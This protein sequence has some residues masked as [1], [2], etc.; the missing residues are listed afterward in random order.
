MKKPVLP[1][2]AG[3]LVLYLAVFVILVTIQSVRQQ[4]FTHRLGGMTISGHYGEADALAGGAPSAPKGAKGFTLTG[5]VSVFFG[6]MEFRMDGKDGEFG[7]LRRGGGK[8]RLLPKYLEISDGTSV[9]GT[10]V[11]ESAAVYFTNAEVP[12]SGSASNG[13]VLPGIK[14]IFTSFSTPGGPELRITG[15][16]GGEFMGAELPYQ[17]MRSARIQES[18]GNQFIILAEGV[19]YSFDRSRT[20]PMRKVLVLEDQGSAISYRA[21]SNNK[22]SFPADFV[23]S[24]AWD[25]GQYEEAIAYWRDQLFSIWART[26]PA[27]IDTEDLVAAYASEA[28]HRGNYKDVVA[29]IPRSFQDS[30]RRTYISSVFFGRLDISLR[31]L[32][33]A[34]RDHTARLT[35][36]LRDN[37]LAFL[38]EPHIFAESGIRGNNAFIDEGAAALA[39]IDLAAIPPELLPAIFEGCTDWPQYR[40][41]AANPFDPF[42]EPARLLIAEGVQMD[43]KSTQS[44]FFSGGRADT[45][46]NLRLGTALD[47]YARLSGDAELAA[48]GRSL[49]LSVISMTDTSGML[50]P[51]VIPTKDGNFTTVGGADPINIAGLYHYLAPITYPRAVGIAAGGINGWAWTIASAV[52]VTRAGDIVDIAVS[53]PQSE[54]HYMIIRGIRPFTKIQLHGVDY[55]T[56]P[57]FELYDSSGWAYSAAEQSLLLK[58]KH[59]ESVEHIKVFYTPLRPS[60]ARLP[61]PEEAVPYPAADTATGGEEEGSD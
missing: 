25:P 30:S 11:G 8:V 33:N 28:I 18:G 4:S 5:Q 40:P 13:T 34:E 48:L 61:P 50:P 9:N 20:D 55:R 49:A 19:N 37:P 43:G 14:L 51:A 7:F 52:E 35:A 58:I 54:T 23:V 21:V 56:D 22:G 3:L 32:S 2:I 41:N 38:Q 10:P 26:V 15:A 45:E 39:A 36:L 53:F 44:L 27:R 46:F 60:P 31:S 17:P 1:R 42:I 47:Q 59:Q 57:Q 24:R 16:F 6:G 12:P 29:R